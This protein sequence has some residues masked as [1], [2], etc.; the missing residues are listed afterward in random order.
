MIDDALANGA[1]LLFGDRSV[2]G[3]NKTILQPHVLDHVKPS[4]AIFRE[5]SFGPI[6]CITRA[7]SEEEAVDLANDSD[8][9][10][11]ASV[12]TRDVLRGMELAQQIRAGSCHV[13]GPT[14]YIEPTLPNGG[15]GG[16]S[17]YGRFGGM[18]G[19][20]EFTERKI[21]SLVKPGMKYPL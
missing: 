6:L 19:V 12:F 4:M 7:D 2:S 9:S 14:V 18:A 17:G 5:E 11:C 13:N 8:Y 1:S 16:R 15:T 10:L 20:E 21:V 3:P